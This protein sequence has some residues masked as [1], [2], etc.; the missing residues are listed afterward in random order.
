MTLKSDHQIIRDYVT[1]MDHLQY[2]TLP[3][4]VVAVLVTHSNLS[5][6]HLDVRIHDI[7]FIFYLHIFIYIFL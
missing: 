2:S 7:L 1:A 3:D 5:A 6:N 4:G